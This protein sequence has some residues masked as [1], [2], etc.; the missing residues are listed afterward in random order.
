MESNHV[1][2]ALRAFKLLYDDGVISQSEWLAQKAKLL[3]V[4]VKL[5]APQGGGGYAA[6]HAAASAAAAAGTLRGR[7]GAAPAARLPS[8]RRRSPMRPSLYGAG[9]PVAT[10][11]DAALSRRWANELM[12][13]PRSSLEARARRWA[14]DERGG[15]PATPRTAAQSTPRRRESGAS[16][17]VHSHRRARSAPPSLR[18]VAPPP[19]WSYGEL[20][21]REQQSLGLTHAPVHSVP[22]WDASTRGSFRRPSTVRRPWQAEH[23]C[24]AVRPL[25]PGNARPKSGLSRAPAPTPRSRASSSSSS[26]SSSRGRPRLSATPQPHTRRLFSDATPTARSIGTWGVRSQSLDRFSPHAA[27]LLAFDS[28]VDEPD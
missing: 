12:S 4:D 6:A 24:P 1:V 9:A 8:P 16:G 7:A 13:P 17:P 14:V 21:L 18:G 28:P 27:G 26:S 3:A 5:A 15:A 25:R 22:C 2:S 23:E 11:A 10:E 20:R 19:S